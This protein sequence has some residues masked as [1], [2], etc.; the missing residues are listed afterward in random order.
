MALLVLTSLDVD[1]IIY[2]FT[3]S[4]LTEL[5]ATTFAKVSST[6]S[7]QRT[8]IETP[9]QTTLFMPSNI[10]GIG[11]GVKVVT[12]AK[13]AGVKGIAST[14]LLLESKHGTSEIAQVIINSRG[15]TALRTAAGITPLINF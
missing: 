15:L 10:S 13:P 8:S 6:G 2:N 1:Q 9:N 11:T 12:V 7:S 3:H 5:M 14:T 4:E